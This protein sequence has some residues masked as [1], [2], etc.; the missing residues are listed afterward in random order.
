MLC[1]CGLNTLYVGGNYENAT[2]SERRKNFTNA[3]T[4]VDVLAW[5]TD[6]RSLYLIQCTLGRS[7]IKEKIDEIGAFVRELR[8]DILT[9][10]MDTPTIYPVIITNALSASIFEEEQKSAKEKGIKI[11]TGELI[12]N[13]VS[14]I[15]NN[16]Y[17]TNDEIHKLMTIEQKN[18]RISTARFDD[19]FP[20]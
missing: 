6:N 18:M 11:V 7:T 13:M 10:H 15:R 5:S 19:S 2:L 16:N 8:N 3:E 1:S 9:K 20:K 17:L 12:S 14:D 4:A